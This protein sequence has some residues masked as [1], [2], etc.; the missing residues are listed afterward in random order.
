MVYTPPGLAGMT[1]T[2]DFSNNVT[3]FAAGN[4]STLTMAS[5][6]GLAPSNLT[7]ATFDNNGVLTLTYA[8]GQEVQGAR[9]A[10]ARFDSADAVIAVGDNQFK[11]EN[12]QGQAWHLGWAG[13]GA[14]GQV[15]A[16]TIEA[17]NVDLSREFSDLI[18]MQR[19]YQAS[20]EVIGT[21]GRMMDQ[22]FAIVNR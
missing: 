2:L 22:L 3:S 10:L 21:A 20:S 6:D 5:Q 13:D 7:G 12:G 19:G 17:S 9:L 8:N 11:S 18:V 15:R 16:G 4:L 14:F 1:L